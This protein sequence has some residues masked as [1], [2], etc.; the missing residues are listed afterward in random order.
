MALL[1]IRSKQIIPRLLSM[2]TLLFNRQTRGTLPRFNRQLV[3]CDNDKINLSVLVDRQTNSN[4]DIG[5]HKN[6]PFL[7]AGSMVAVQWEDDN[8]SH[9]EQLKDADQMTREAE[10]TGYG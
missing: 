3:L 6:I 8:H 9:R 10:A 1:Q 2:A 5:T 7:P 4:E